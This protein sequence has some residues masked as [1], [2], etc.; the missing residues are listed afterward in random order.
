MTKIS[1]HFCQGEQ[2]RGQRLYFLQRCVVQQIWRREESIA[3]G[4]S[5]DGLSSTWSR[6]AGS[7]PDPP[8]LSCLSPSLPA[9]LE[10]Q[11]CFPESQS[12]SCALSL[13]CCHFHVE[14]S[15]WAHMSSLYRNLSRMSFG[16]CL[17]KDPCF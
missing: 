1:W 9:E 14:S 7:F 5:G 17:S 13:S 8:S 6:K 4:P 16:L 15:P 2:V 11:S 12:F 10:C 3:D